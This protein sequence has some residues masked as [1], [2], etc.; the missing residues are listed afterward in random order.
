MSLLVA[1]GSTEM[2]GLAR[3]NVQ[4]VFLARRDSIPRRVNVS[5]PTLCWPAS[6]LEATVYVKAADTHFEIFA[7]GIEC[8]CDSLWLELAQMNCKVAV[9]APTLVVGHWRATC[10]DV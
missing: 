6:S 10:L 4:W 7:R 5:R 2:H 1:C 9:F 3:L 8:V